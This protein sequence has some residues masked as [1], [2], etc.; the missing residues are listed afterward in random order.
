M[1]KGGIQGTWSLL[2]IKLRILG[3]L[4]GYATTWLHP[5]L[6]ST[7]DIQLFLQ[8]KQD[9]ASPCATNPLTVW[10]YS[11]CWGL[12]SS[13]PLGTHRPLGKMRVSLVTKGCWKQLVRWTGNVCDGTPFD[14]KPQRI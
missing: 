14:T 13:C 10:R 8:G 11:L 7:G 2:E 6:P 1:G 4:G 12:C 3:V 5:Q 9:W